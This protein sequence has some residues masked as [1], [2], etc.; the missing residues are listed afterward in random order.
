[1]RASSQVYFFASFIDPV[2]FHIEGLGSHL[3]GYHIVREVIHELRGYS[4]EDIK[5]RHI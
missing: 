3:R 1:M 4:I 2:E 5:W